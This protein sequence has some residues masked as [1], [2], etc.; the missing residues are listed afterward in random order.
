M[1]ERNVEIIKRQFKKEVMN[2]QSNLHIFPEDYDLVQI[3]FMDNETGLISPH[4]PV[5]V[6]SANSVYRSLMKG[7]SNE[8]LQAEQAQISKT[9]QSN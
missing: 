7:V 4:T 5:L 2:P 1:S 9:V 8:G 3:G 6:L